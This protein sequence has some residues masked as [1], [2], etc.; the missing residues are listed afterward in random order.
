MSQDL[1]VTTASRDDAIAELRF[2]VVPL[3]VFAGISI[4]FVAIARDSDP[5]LRAMMRLA[6]AIALLVCAAMLSGRAR[7]VG[8]HY[9]SAA[10]R[11]LGAAC[12]LWSLVLVFAA[13]VLAITVF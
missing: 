9:P 1:A 13:L 6:L 2:R 10:G 5:G 4:A 8:K 12:W 3:L 11:W 7:L